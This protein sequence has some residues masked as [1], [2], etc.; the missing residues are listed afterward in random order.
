MGFDIIKTQLSRL[1]TYFLMTLHHN[2]REKWCLPALLAQGRPGVS[3]L[4]QE[5]GNV[6]L[7]F[8]LVSGDA[9]WVRI[10]R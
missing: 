5:C 3:A 8:L 2:R 9:P 7:E 4:G 1:T 6:L 10:E